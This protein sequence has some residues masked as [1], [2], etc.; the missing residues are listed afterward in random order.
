MWSFLPT[1]LLQEEA[2][3]FLFYFISLIYLFLLLFL[4]TPVVFRSSQMRDQTCATP[5]TRATAVTTLILNLLSHQGMPNPFFLGPR[6]APDFRLK[7]FSLRVSQI[8]V[9]ES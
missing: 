5:V 4:A 6:F 1:L 7:L 9:K 3:P 2:V 8:P